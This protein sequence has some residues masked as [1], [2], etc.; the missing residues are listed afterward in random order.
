MDANDHSYT[1]SDSSFGG[2]S[3]GRHVASEPMIAGKNAGRALM[4]RA[5]SGKAPLSKYKSAASVLIELRETTKV[6]GR[7]EKMFYYRVDKIKI[8]PAERVTKKFKGGVEFTPLFTYHA[9][10]IEASEFARASK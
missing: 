1:I 10:A 4:R 2:W 6:A 7:K 3:G 5:E 9:K 8:P